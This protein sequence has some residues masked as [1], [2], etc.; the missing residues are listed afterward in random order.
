MIG[1][2]LKIMHLEVGPF[3]GNIFIIA[4]YII[5][6]IPNIILPLIFAVKIRNG[7][8]KNYYPSLFKII[9]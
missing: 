7:E 3:S 9:K 2:F 4:T 5:F 6:Y 1:I 8:I